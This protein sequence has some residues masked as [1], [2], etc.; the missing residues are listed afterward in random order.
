LDPPSSL[1]SSKT[2]GLQGYLYLSTI[3]DIIH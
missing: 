3:I 2:C 1:K